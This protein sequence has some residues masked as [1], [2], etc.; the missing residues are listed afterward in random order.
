[1]KAKIINKSFIINNV[2]LEHISI[3]E[4]VI[5]IEL[6]DVN[7]NRYRMVFKPY[8]AL[9]IT[10]ADCF[11]KDILLI[12]ES[13]ELGIYQRHILEV[14]NSEWIMQLKKALKENDEDASFMKESRHFIVDLRDNILE[15]SAVDFEL[16]EIKD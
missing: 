6:D 16:S 9:K 13:F 2:P 15:I 12:R 3:E 14:E 1:M 4:Y 10:T 7:E 5:V 8:Q 11:D